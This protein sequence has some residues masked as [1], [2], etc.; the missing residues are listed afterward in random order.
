MLRAIMNGRCL[1]SRQFDVKEEDAPSPECLQKSR[2]KTGKGAGAMMLC[3]AYSLLVTGC[4]HKSP[5]ESMP[6]DTRGAIASPRVCFG[7]GPL[8]KRR[9][10]RIVGRPYSIGGKWY[11]PQR[12]P[13]YDRVGVASWYGDAF[14]GRLTANGEV[15]DMTA[16]TAAHPTLPL[17]SLVRV[18]NLNDGRSI[19]VRVNDRGPFVDGRLIDLSRAA[20]QQLGIMRLGIAR[21]RVQYLGPAKD[22]P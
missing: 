8:P 20:A 11:R 18:T 6:I 17:P 4:S 19:V 10:R 21:V 22:Y 14:H 2:S 3:A 1:L 7:K 12:D 13:H 9:G 15:F 16:I 5:T